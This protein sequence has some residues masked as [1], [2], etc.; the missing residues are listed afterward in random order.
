MRYMVGLVLVLALGVTGCNQSTAGPIGGSGGSAGM[1]GGGTGGEGG[2]IGEVFPCTEQGIRDAIAEGG[3]HAFAC[4]GA[5]PVVTQAEI[6][7]DNNVILDGQGNLTVDGD[8][9]HIVFRV[10]EGTVC[11]LW[12]HRE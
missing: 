5:Q 3:P 12:L 1:G 8:D 6:V 4:D 11:A 2:A 7:V 10:A 9:D